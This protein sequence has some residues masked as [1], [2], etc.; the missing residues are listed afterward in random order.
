MIICE[1]NKLNPRSAF[2]PKRKEEMYLTFKNGYVFALSVY[3]F[4]VYCISVIG[5]ACCL[6]RMFSMFVCS[7]TSEISFWRNA[8]LFNRLF[9]DWI[10]Y[11]E[12]NRKKE[13][14]LIILKV[15]QL[16]KSSKLSNDDLAFDVDKLLRSMLGCI[17]R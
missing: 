10:L 11:M 12:K 6:Y 9:I 3:L 5:F 4:E 13:N 14:F 16:L 7:E 2:S 8:V 1:F 17:S 15:T